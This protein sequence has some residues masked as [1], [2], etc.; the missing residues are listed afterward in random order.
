MHELNNTL[1]AI[2]D[3]AVE[4]GKERGA[5][6]AVWA[7]GR[8]VASCFAGHADAARATPVDAATLFPVFSVTK[9]ITAAAIHRMAQDG[10]LAY[11]APIADIW[12]AFGQCGKEGITVRHA[13]CHTAG[14]PDLPNDL[15]EETLNDWEA[16]CALL[17]EMPP[18]YAPGSRI[19]Y[20][21][22]TFGWILGELARRAD[23]RALGDMIADEI[24]R[25]LGLDGLYLA[26]DAA[27]DARVAWLTEEPMPAKP[28]GAY[29]SVPAGVS[30]LITWRNQPHVRRLPQPASS[31]VMSADALA[32]FYAALLPGGVDGVSLLQDGTRAQ[33]VT[34]T[35]G[36]ENP[37]NRA[38]G[39]SI[40][41]T[42][43]LLGHAGIAFG[44][45]GYG[46]SIGFANITH[47]FAFAYTHNHFS[48]A[49]YE[50]AAMLLDAAERALA[51]TG[52]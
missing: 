7:G 18:Q 5:Q 9:G 19:A 50:V 17:E 13:L 8:Q 39:F 36:L 27:T 30:P 26:S 43:P 41:G 31:G 28:E 6:V 4:T 44:H 10:R 2:L 25:P 42:N 16:M 3:G 29:A 35:A 1:Q 34:P 38:M 49:G 14:L 23:G 24:A 22:M 15:P 32:K 48:P 33:V 47:G 40:S 21:A 45:I 51:G 37:D 20:H 11:D 12:P 52:R 46:G